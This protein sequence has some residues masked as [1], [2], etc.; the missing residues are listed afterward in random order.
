MMHPT[1]YIAKGNEYK[2]CKL[3][4]STYGLKQASRLCNKKFEQTVQIEKNVDE[5]YI[6]K[7][8]KDGNVIFLVLYVDNIVLIGNDVRILLFV[9][10]WLI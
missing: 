3:L 5:P 6:Y 2:V 1:E 4:R 10:L 7:R 9:K 8:I